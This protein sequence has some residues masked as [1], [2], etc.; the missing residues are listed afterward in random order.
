MIDSPPAAPVGDCPAIYLYQQLRLVPLLPRSKTPFRSDRPDP[1]TGWR[2]RI[3]DTE[4]V[5]AAFRGRYPRCNLALISPGCQVDVDGQ[6][7]LDWAKSTGLATEGAWVLRTGR[8]WRLLFAPPSPCPPTHTSP[9]HQTPDLLAPGR[10]AVVPPSIHPSGRAY[11]WLP[12]HSPLEIPATELAS[13]PAAILGAWRQ[14]K[15][16]STSSH[17]RARV[18]GWLDLV[19]QAVCDYL[20]H[21]G[22]H[23]RP[24]GNG[25]LT[26]TCPFHEDRNPSFS[27]HPERGWICFA[28]CGQGRLTQLAARLGI[29]AGGRSLDGRR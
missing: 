26:T 17:R 24:V 18:P 23:L 10:L 6:E 21:M 11:A 22:H 16:P 3:L 19:F 2:M 14:L 1:Q 7:A 13:L 25:G 27:L 8:G 29:R 9:T 12:R 15:R 20:E 5:W 4:Q 28:G